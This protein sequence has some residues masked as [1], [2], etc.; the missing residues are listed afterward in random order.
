ME[1]H[2]FRLSPA[3]KGQGVSC[4]ENGAFIGIIPLLKCVDSAGG[5]SWQTIDP[6]R[7]SREV[8]A[9]FGLP[10]DMSRK[11]AGLK[12]IADALTAGD[13]PRAQIATVL[14]AIPDAPPLSKSAQSR[15]AMLQFIRDLHWSGMLKSDWDP[16]EHPRW[17]AGAP[18]SQGGQFAPKREGGG[19]LSSQTDATDRS[20]RIQLADA[21]MSDAIDDPVAEAV[22]AAAAA[23]RHNSTEPRSQPKAVRSHEDD[24]QTFGSRVAQGV[25]FALTEIGRAEI[26]ENQTNISASI[27]VAHAIG[28]ALRDYANYRAQPWLDSHGNPIWVSVINNGDPFSDRSELMGHELFAPSAPLTRPGTNADWIDP[29]LDLVSVG[30]T[31]AGPAVRAFGAG[32]RITADTSIVAADT[33]FIILPKE[34]FPGF[35]SRLPIGKYTIPTNAVPRTTTYGELVGEQIGN[36]VQIASPTTEMILRT[37]PGIK[38]V[39]IELKAEDAFVAGFRYA[40]IKPVTDSGFRTFN[41]QLARWKLSEPVLAITYDYDGNIYYGFP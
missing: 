18:D 22:R 1:A 17:P 35:D 38:G 27:T 2:A 39:D 36:L 8:G 12:V 13:I 10:I 37:A 40:E 11:A 32:A 25:E 29:M 6:A 30:A 19:G 26:S 16:D 14:L 4:D 34:L 28:G 15:E 20:P 3:G 9:Q 21:G 41:R 24:T 31:V 7:L 23:A 5:P 33:P